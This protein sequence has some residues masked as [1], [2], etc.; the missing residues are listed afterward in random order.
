MFQFLLP[1]IAEKVHMLC[2]S[3]YLI[4]ISKSG[5]HV[6]F[7]YFFVCRLLV[8]MY[9]TLHIPTQK[10]I[11]FSFLLVILTVLSDVNTAEQVV[12]CLGT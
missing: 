12:S 7:K 9:L 1:V 11:N 2:G 8:N 3:R 10:Y 4:V 6:T 5:T